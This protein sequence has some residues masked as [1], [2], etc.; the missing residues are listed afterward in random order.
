MTRPGLKPEPL[1]PESSALTA[2]PPRLLVSAKQKDKY[3][4]F[5]GCCLFISGKLQLNKTRASYGS[6]EPRV[7]YIRNRM[8]RTFYSVAIYNW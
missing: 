4:T 5:R 2:R 1:D 8:A 7:L 6:K 3:Q